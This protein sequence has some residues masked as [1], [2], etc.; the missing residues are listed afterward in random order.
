M[1]TLDPTNKAIIDL[2]AIPSPAVLAG[3]LDIPVSMIHQGRQDGKLPAK[4]TASYRECI[5]QYLHY[6]KKKINSK[7]TSMG[8]AKLAQDIRNGIAKEQQQWLEIKQTK[9]ELLDVA[10]LKDL[11]EPIFQLI[12]SS[13][14]N[15][16]RRHPETQK[17]IDNMLESL[18]VL[19]TKIASKANSDANN[20]V[21]E[22]L[23]R[24]LTLGEAEE[25]IEESFNLE[26]QH[27]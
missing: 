25:E 7:S 8:E 21:V 11:F 10:V 14:V 20:Y 18:Y 4:T 1:T 24:E 16:A 19:G 3:I 26:E 17:D 13:L 15:V 12:R 23:E 27:G 5:H 2:D 6:Y 22:M 9:Q